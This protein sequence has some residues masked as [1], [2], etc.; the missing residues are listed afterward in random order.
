VE[1]APAPD[2]NDLERTLD[3]ALAAHPEA[4]ISTVGG[5]L[6][7][8][9]PQPKPANAVITGFAT[10]HRLPT[11]TSDSGVAGN[12]LYYGPNL[13]ALYRHTSNYDVDR[14]L[15][16][17]NPV[18]LPVDGPTVFDLVVNRTTAQALGLTIPPDVAAQVSEWLE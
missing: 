4:I 9:E 6:V 7:T 10:Q 3:A 1:I 16:G 5:A 12:L 18:D 15:R 2:L 14:I 17:A 11:A 13:V 8:R